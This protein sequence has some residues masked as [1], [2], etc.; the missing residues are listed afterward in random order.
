MD[1]ALREKLIANE[2]DVDGTM[3][4]FLNNEALYFKCLKKFLTDPNF[5]MLKKAKAEGNV[6]EA[7]K[8]AHTMKGFLS[9][10]G[11]NKIY[12]PLQPVVEKLRSGDINIDE[13][14]VTLERLYKETYEIV[15]SIE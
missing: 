4:R 1:D 11:I 10:L 14:L 2:F 7:F 8:S 3:Q 12:V 9:N 13:E 15:E 5:E 6:E